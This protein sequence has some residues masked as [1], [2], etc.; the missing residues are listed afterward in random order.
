MIKKV[1]IT[2]G[3]LGTRFLPATKEQPKEMLPIF[4][5]TNNRICTKPFVQK[6]YED[7]YKIGFRKFCFIINDKKHVIR[8]HFT[9]DLELINI[10]ESRNSIFLEDM[11][12]FYSTLKKSRISWIKQP[13]AKGFGHAVYMAKKF[14]GKDDFLLH[15]GDDM[16]ISKKI[17]PI[18]RLCKIH[19][20]YKADATFIVQKTSDPKRYGVALC[21][22]IEK[23]VYKVLNV[24]EKPKKPKSNLAII[25]FYIFKPSIFSA[26]KKVKPDKGGE[27]QLTDAIQFLIERGKK[28][29]AMELGKN[30][31][32]IDIGIPETYKKVLEKVL[33]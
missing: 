16:V 22:P 29:L 20:K 14:V 30:E 19:E 4:C 26:L 33:E 5:K 27:I 1:V 25:A 18:L 28:V 6:V 2:A 3:G 8:K 21:K 24:E 7:L 13:E 9:Q 12:R 11:K 17:N 32:R 10:L 15:V 31:K 23:G